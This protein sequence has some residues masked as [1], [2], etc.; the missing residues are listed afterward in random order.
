MYADQGSFNSGGSAIAGGGG[1]I[2]SAQGGTDG[3]MCTPEPQLEPKAYAGVGQWS[4]SPAAIS[5][6]QA[7]GGHM[8]GG[9]IILGVAGAPD[10]QYVSQ[11]WGFQTQ[12]TV[13][14]PFMRQV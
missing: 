2:T 7:M 3:M 13:A 11:G 5:A 12:G 10:Q 1:G 6:W 14:G 4:P 8:G 9:G